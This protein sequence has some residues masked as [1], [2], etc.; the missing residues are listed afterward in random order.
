M[1][2]SWTYE[3]P[4][5]G[6]D[7]AGLEDYMVE[8]RDGEAVGK[9]VALLERGGER[10]LL[11]DSGAPPVAKERRAARW[12]DV[13]EIDHETLTI[14]LRTGLDEALEL[15]PARE[16]EDGNAEAVR[17]T[18][19][20]R[21]LAV[22]AVPERGPTDRPTYAGGIVLFAVGLVGLLVLALAASTAEFTWEFALFAIPI[23]LIVAAAAVL[24]R[25]W[26]EPY[27]RR[28]RE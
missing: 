28:P 21:G 22:P 19:L 2:A 3:V 27:E 4:P 23:L 1:R 26:R 20:P 5:A 24:Y 25:A 14:T 11:F 17:V 6:A 13:A 12:E 15:D 18:R 16:V 8:T 9:V 10:F 7:A